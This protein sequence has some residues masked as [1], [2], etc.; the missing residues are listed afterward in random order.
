MFHSSDDG[1]G[2]RRFGPLEHLNDRR[3]KVQ[4]FLF[5]KE[6]GVEGCEGPLSSFVIHY[7][8]F[9]G[10]VSIF[11]IL[12]KGLKVLRRFKASKFLR[13]QKRSTAFEESKGL[14]TSEGASSIF[15]GRVYAK[16]NMPK[17]GVGDLF[18][19]LRPHATYFHRFRCLQEPFP[20]KL[21]NRKSLNIC[22][23]RPHKRATSV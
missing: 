2:A 17:I 8:R 3:S 19:Q 20:K 12:A 1:E 7:R 10:P 9:K 4:R 6:F 13:K 18:G 23:V 22:Q 14:Q 16:K 11:V 15:D 21:L 5:L